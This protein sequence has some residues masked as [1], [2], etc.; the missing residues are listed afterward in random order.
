MHAV[1]F[2]TFLNSDQNF[3]AELQY[4]WKNTSR[5]KK[6]TTTQ[7]MGPEYNASLLS[8]LR[9]PQIKYATAVGRSS[10]SVY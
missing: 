2:I 1:N 5:I 7:R 9:K 10:R 3:E 4:R 8:L 6:N